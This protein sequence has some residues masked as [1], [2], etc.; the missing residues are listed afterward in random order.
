MVSSRPEDPIAALTFTLASDAPAGLVA[1]YV[2]GSH[3]AGRAHRESDVDIGV[4]LRRD[5]FPTVEARFH[6]GVRLAEA[7]G[8]AAPSACG[9]V[10]LTDATPGLAALDQ[11]EPVERF[12]AIVRDLEKP[13]S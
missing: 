8:N 7:H 6:E 13:A 10:E 5:H 9:S 1:V 4:L 3:A 11:L 12:L 2:F